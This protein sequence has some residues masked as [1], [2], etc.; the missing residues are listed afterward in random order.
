MSN[1]LIVSQNMNIGGVQKYTYQLYQALIN[2]N[3]K[4]DIKCRDK[5]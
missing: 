2:L 3:Y 1:I 5:N 4:V